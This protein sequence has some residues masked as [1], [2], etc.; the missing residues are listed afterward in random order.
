[1]AYTKKITVQEYSET[2]DSIGNMVRTWQTLFSP[3]AEI[4][5][6]TGKEYYEAAQI[7]SENDVVFKIRYSRCMAEKLSSELRIIYNGKYYDI[8]RI[9]DVNEQHRQFVI[10]AQIINGGGR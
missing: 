2:D 6:A 1:M 4:S 7:N 10:R 9:D 3:W 5:T 8:R